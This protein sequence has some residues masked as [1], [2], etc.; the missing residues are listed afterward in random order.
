MWQQHVP[1]SGR[2][3]WYRIYQQYV[4]RDFSPVAVF[5]F[6]GFGFFLWGTG[7]GLYTWWRSAMTGDIATTGTVM[8]SVLPFLIGF[9]LSSQAVILDIQTTPK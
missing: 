5:L 9:D 8:L 3:F 4:L 7:F 1:I 6:I 2:R